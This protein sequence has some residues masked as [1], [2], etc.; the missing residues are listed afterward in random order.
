M[1]TPKKFC[2]TL[3]RDAWV[4]Y[5]AEIEAESAKEAAESALTA[6]KDGSIKF[7][8]GGLNEFDDVECDPDDD[9]EEME[10]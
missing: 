3:R 8:E 2:V 6:W 4:N 1:T 5:Q 9:V 10:P 7:E